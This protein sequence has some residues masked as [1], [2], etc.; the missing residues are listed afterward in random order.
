MRRAPVIVLL[1]TSTAAHGGGL[2]IVNGSP[3]AIGRAGTSTVGDDGAG[4]LLAN[5]AAMARREGYRAQAGFAFVDDELAWQSTTPGAPITRDQAQ[6]SI[7]PYVGVFGSVGGWVIGVG[8]MTSAVSDRSLRPPRD[9]PDPEDF[10]VAFDYRYLGI[11]GGSRR[12][13]VT[14]GVARRLGDS[15]ALGISLAAS[16]V[17][18]TEVRRVWA[19]FSGRDMVG[20]PLQDVELGFSGKDRFAP[21]AVAGLLIAPAHTSIELGASVAWAATAKID[22]SVIGSGTRPGP[23]VAS[24]SSGASLT[25]EQPVTIRAG[26]R[27]VGDRFV[28]ELGGEV[29]IAP[30]AAANHRWTIDSMRVVDPT[31]VEVTL[32]SVP[33]RISM[34][35]HGAI[36]GAVDAELIPGFLWATAGYA[37]T[38]GAVAATKQSPI[39]GDLGG[40]TLGLGLEG[41]AGGFTLTLGWSRTWSMARS[42]T[43]QFALDN[44][45]NA[46]DGLTPSGLYDGSVDQLGILLD[47]ELAPN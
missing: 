1:L 16:R 22:A 8:A 27:Y 19:G 46:G 14:A 20:S 23:S 2:V 45:F 29:S 44:P 12:D 7:A 11:A 4:A 34:R 39:F 42:S 31:G 38:V 40:H 5:P 32:A 10:G 17:Q 3:K 13:T 26:G 15:V 28:A 47:V 41:T 24:D 9:V 35:T 18:V 30:R 36:R 6:S 37:Y 25:L 43:T 21:S 33:S